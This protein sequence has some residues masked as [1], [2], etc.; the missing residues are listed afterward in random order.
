MSRFQRT[1]LLVLAL[2]LAAALPVSAATETYA[3]DPSHSQVT[4]N[5]RHIV[6][7][8]NGRF[9]KVSGTIVLDRDDLSTAKITAEVDAASI[10]TANDNRDDKLRSADYFDTATYPVMSFQSTEVVPKEMG[11][12][13]V[14]GTLTMHGVTKPVELDAE[15][16]GFEP[17]GRGGTRGGFV[18]RTQVLRSDFGIAWDASQVG[19]KL[20]LGNEVEVILQIEGVRTEP[21]PEESPAEGD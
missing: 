7:L 19:A 13:T 1:A 18:G 12:A 21:K 17:D 5:I 6:S 16:L 20:A 9:N 14:K 10:D 4:F 2:C 11:K 3:I 8:F 15:I